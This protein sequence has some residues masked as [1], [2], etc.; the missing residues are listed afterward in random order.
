MTQLHRPI[1][2]QKAV[3]KFSLHTWTTRAPVDDCELKVLWPSPTSPLLLSV[4]ILLWQPVF[5][6]PFRLH[7]CWCQL[8]P[9]ELPVVMATA[10]YTAKKLGCPSW[11]LRPLGRLRRTFGRK[12]DEVTGEWRKLHSEELHKLYSSPDSIRQIKSGRMRLAGNVARMEYQRRVCK[13][14]VGMLVGKRPHGRPRSR[15]MGPEWILG[16]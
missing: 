7:A 5:V 9:E 15:W 3:N 8:W 12:R 16:R 4:T 2:W 10:W 14:L 11:S 1:R 6:M 13:V